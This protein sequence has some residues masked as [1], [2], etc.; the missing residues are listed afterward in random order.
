MSPMHAPCWLADQS[1]HTFNKAMHK[2]IVTEGLSFKAQS[3]SF[4]LT[5][6]TIAYEETDAT[7]YMLLMKCSPCSS[8]DIHWS[9]SLGKACT[10]EVTS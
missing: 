9:L 3:A 1:V 5:H 7:I 6:H 8:V 10:A 2:E 4:L